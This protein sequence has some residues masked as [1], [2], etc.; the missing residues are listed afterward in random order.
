M[1]FYTVSYSKRWRCGA[2]SLLVGSG[3]SNP[4]GEIGL[5]SECKSQCGGT[6]GSERIPIPIFIQI[7][8]LL[9]FDGNLWFAQKIHVQNVNL[10]TSIYFTD[11]CILCAGTTYWY[12]PTCNLLKF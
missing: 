2:D 6:G 10:S 5:L 3:F 4:G 7:Q 1:I 12:L 8:V 9:G 11:D